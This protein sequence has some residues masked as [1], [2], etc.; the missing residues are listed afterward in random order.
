M[1]DV[2]LKFPVQTGE[3]AQLFG[4]FLS[5]F[6]ESQTSEVERLAASADAP[7][8]M[9]RTDLDQTGEIR[10]LIFQE[11]SAASAFSTGWAEMLTGHALNTA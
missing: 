4:R 11:P 6:I 8:L 7:Y 1:S 9:M 5:S 10:V 2:V 3:V